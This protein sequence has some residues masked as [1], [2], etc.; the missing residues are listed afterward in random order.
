MA[1]DSSGPDPEVLASLVGSVPAVVRLAGGIGQVATYLPGRRVSGVRI[2]PSE[3]EVHVVA[4][5]GAS[6][7]DVG[8][9]VR[10]AVRAVVGARTVSVFIE[11]VELSEADGQAAP[12]PPIVLR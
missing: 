4:R 9:A 10:D 7:P 12:P 2:T 8:T 6:L 11:D 3:V 5:Y 1:G